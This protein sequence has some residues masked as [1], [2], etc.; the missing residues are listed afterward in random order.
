MFCID[1]T[2]QYIDRVRPCTGFQ[3]INGGA[4]LERVLLKV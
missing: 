4:T 1:N 3:T 2:V